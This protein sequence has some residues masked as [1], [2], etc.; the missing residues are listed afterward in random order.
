MVDTGDL[1]SRENC[2]TNL[3]EVIYVTMI[4]SNPIPRPIPWA[5]MP[6]RVRVPPTLQFA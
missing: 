2:L 3:V 4:G 6:V 1:I 5:A